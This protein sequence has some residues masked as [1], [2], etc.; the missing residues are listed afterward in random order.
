MSLANWYGVE[1]NAMHIVTPEQNNNSPA[2]GFR[3]PT[4]GHAEPDFRTDQAMTRKSGVP[5]LLL[6]G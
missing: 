2:T 4:K 6:G 1:F 3:N 5:Y